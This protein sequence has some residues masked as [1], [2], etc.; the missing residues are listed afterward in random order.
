MVSGDTAPFVRE[1]FIWQLKCI[2]DV[3]WETGRKNKF[4]FFKYKERI[5]G[6]CGYLTTCVC[7]VVSLQLAAF[8]KG[9]D[10]GGTVEDPGLL[11]AGRWAR[12]VEFLVFLQ[13]EPKSSENITSMRLQRKLPVSMV[14]AKSREIAHAGA[15]ECVFPCMLFWSGHS[16]KPD[17]VFFSKWLRKVIKYWYSPLETLFSPTFNSTF[18]FFN[19]VFFIIYNQRAYKPGPLQSVKPRAGLWQNNETQETLLWR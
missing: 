9:F 5:N 15:G 10:T 13:A 11:G 17:L 3:K 7:A 14:T 18:H 8:G 16:W 19:H 6:S 4:F 12:L 2:N 1:S